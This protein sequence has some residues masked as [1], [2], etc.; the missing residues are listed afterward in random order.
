LDAL[1]AE[2]G[3]LEAEYR[4]RMRSVSKP[5]IDKAWS[6]PGQS[7]DLPSDLV[8][9]FRSCV[10][11]ALGGPS[12]VVVAAPAVLESRF[13]KASRELPTNRLVLAR[14]HALVDDE[15]HLT[16]WGILLVRRLAESEMGFDDP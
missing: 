8:D 16:A 15:N 4:L 14:Q 3:A 9:I 1:V 12:E 6:N 11:G 10:R 5:S 13:A 2:V 7:L